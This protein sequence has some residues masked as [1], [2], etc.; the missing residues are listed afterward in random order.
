MYDP[1]TALLGLEAVTAA[2]PENAAIVAL[3]ELATDAKYDRDELTLTVARESIVPR[4]RG[5]EGRRL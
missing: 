1:A 3:K 2:H 4:L 5:A